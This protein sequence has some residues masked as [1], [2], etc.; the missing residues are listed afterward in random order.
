MKDAECIDSC[1]IDGLADDWK[2]RFEAYFLHDLSSLKRR[3]I[4]M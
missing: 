1:Y 4:L 3:L 2:N